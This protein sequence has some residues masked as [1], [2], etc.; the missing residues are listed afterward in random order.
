MPRGLGLIV[1]GIEGIGKTTFALQF[2]K[3]MSFMPLKEPGFDNLNDVGDVPKG[4]SRLN[5][6]SWTDILI[7]VKACQAK[8]LVID[9]ISGLQE[10]L[11]T[12]ITDTCYKGNYTAFKSF[13]NGLRQDCPREVMMLL[14]NI[15]ALRAQGTNVIFISHRKNDVDPDSSGSV[16]DGPSLDGDLLIQ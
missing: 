11:I 16:D 5:C 2:P 13:Y 3:P 9:A 14:D 8:T 10:Y 6:T 12:Y 7:A 1:Y 15:E 4:V